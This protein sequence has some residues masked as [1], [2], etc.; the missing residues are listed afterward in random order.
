MR[1]AEA[2]G[3]GDALVRTMRSAGE[4]RLLLG[5][6]DGARELLQ[7]TRATI[8]SLEADGFELPAE[9]LLG[10]LVSSLDAG[11]PQEVDLARRAVALAPQAM[12]DANAWWDLPR[13][14]RHVRAHAELRDDP[15]LAEGL[16]A[17]AIIEEQRADAR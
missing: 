14:A 2:A 15:A 3:E 13:L 1:A 4:A 5:D 8:A 7:K 11:S 9:D 12:V 17:L 16:A 6:R 10:V